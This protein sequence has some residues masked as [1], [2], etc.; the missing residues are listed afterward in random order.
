MKAEKKH[1]LWKLP[2]KTVFL[3][4]SQSRHPNSSCKQRVT[5]K[6][7]GCSSIICSSSESASIICGLLAAVEPAVCDFMLSL[8]DDTASKQPNVASCQKVDRPAS[9]FGQHSDCVKRDTHTLLFWID[10]IIHL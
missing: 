10:V 7:A 2:Q 6:I 5:V 4:R 1:Y 8:R 3:A 9:S